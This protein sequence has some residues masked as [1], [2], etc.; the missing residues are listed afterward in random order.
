MANASGGNITLA[1]EGTSSGDTLTIGAGVSATGGNGGINLYG[2]DSVIVNATRTVSAVG[3]GTISLFGGKNYAAGT[4]VA[5]LA[6]GDATVN[7]TLSSAYW[8]GQRHS[9]RRYF[10]WGRGNHHQH[11]RERDGDCGRGHEW[12]RNRR[13]LVHGERSGDQRGKRDD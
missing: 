4:P 7:G 3:T 12:L 2:G 6:T 13:G 10:V 5:G 11:Q 1:A 8:R 9:P